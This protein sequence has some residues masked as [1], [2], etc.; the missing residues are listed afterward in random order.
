MRRK[1][2]LVLAAVVAAVSL[3][4]C[5]DNKEPL[6]NSSESQ[7]S[8]NN[9]SST[10]QESGTNSTAEG[11]YPKCLTIENNV[12]VKCDKEATEVVVP[13][14][15]TKISSSSFYDCKNI[16]VTYKGKTYDYSHIEEL[17]EAANG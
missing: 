14:G 9:N 2:A 13:D 15:V 10:S 12:V 5:S 4:G 1:I 16:S 8:G 6:N 17:Y 7:H 3:V 11:N